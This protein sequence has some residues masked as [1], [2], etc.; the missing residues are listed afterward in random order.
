MS[1]RSHPLRMSTRSRPFWK[2]VSTKCHCPRNV[3]IPTRLLKCFV[4][5]HS[6][7]KT[8]NLRSLIRGFEWLEILGFSL[9]LK[10]LFARTRL[11]FAPP[12]LSDDK[13][14][15]FLKSFDLPNSIS[16]LYYHI[17][18]PVLYILPTRCFIWGCL[19]SCHAGIGLFSPKHIN[20]VLFLYHGGCRL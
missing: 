6:V 10:L 14:Y 18:A 16:L 11:Y 4:L 1:T 3:S 5:Q 8:K 9:L 20:Q 12:N 17:L 13:L 19:S 15:L 7:I 2:I